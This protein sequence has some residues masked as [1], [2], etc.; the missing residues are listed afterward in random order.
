VGLGSPLDELKTAFD[1]VTFFDIEQN[2]EQLNG[3][4]PEL[5][6]EIQ[7]I[8][9]EA[10]LLQGEVETDGLVDPQFVDAAGG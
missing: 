9:I 5:V 3:P 10:K 4:F 6:G 7:D 2:R 8:M 1:G